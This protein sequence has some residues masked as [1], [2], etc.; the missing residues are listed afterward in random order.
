MSE[1]PGLDLSG[2]RTWL[3]EHHP[4]LLSGP[5]TSTA[6]TG[7]RSN[8]T[9]LVESPQ[10]Q[11]VLRR[12]PLGDQP[13]TAHDVARE[14]RI[15]TALTPSAVPV[16]RGILLCEDA[17]AIGARFYLMQYVAGLVLRTDQDV[18]PYDGEAKAALADR[19]MDTLAA[20]HAVDLDDAGL[21]DLGR[22]EGYLRR[23]LDRWQRHLEVWGADSPHRAGLQD[24]GRRLADRMPA[25]ERISLVH[26]DFRLDNLIVDPDLRV[27]AVIDW[28]MATLGD[29]LADLGLFL[30]YWDLA[31][32]SDNALS[33][34]M[35][36]AA[37]FPAGDHLAAHYAERTGADLSDLD[38]YV[39][40]GAFKLA[41]VLEGVRL[42]ESQ[43][44]VPG[45][46]S[47][48]GL[49]PVLLDRA[50]QG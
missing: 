6:L 50:R 44:P 1:L 34:A 8:L 16:P 42:R 10:T 39:A 11:V 19:L 33:T 17:D 14:F 29:P 18:A 38:W 45:Y 26:G 30:V 12:P 28:E 40:F 15:I 2:L 22:P 7:G 46:R 48:A 3:D 35:G 13:A 4:G 36:P 20:V 37:G 32:E 31:G 25:S 21:S 24:A 9:F 41:V 5:L 23:Q 43:H 47:V 27:L 49:I